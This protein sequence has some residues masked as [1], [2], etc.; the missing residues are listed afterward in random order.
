MLGLHY[1]VPWPNREMR[2]GAAVP[3]LAACT[4]CWSRPNAN[5]GSRMGWE[6]ANF[7]APAGEDPDHRL[8][9]GQAELAALVGRRAGQHP[10]RRSPSSTRRRSRSTS[11]PGRTRSPALQWLCTADVDVPVGRAVYTGLLNARGTY[12]SDVTV[13]R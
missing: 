5:F 2:D 8:L 12:E 10:R 11:S 7:F 13:T 4:T 1:A 3:P 9:L 6:R